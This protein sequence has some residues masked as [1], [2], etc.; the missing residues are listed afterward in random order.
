MGYFEDRY[1]MLEM[2]S[3]VAV[4]TKIAEYENN[5]TRECLLLDLKWT[6]C[7]SV[8]KTKKSKSRIRPDLRCCHNE[9]SKEY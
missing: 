6:S 1:E 5:E 9:L 4:F 8:D 2:M 7:C 3:K